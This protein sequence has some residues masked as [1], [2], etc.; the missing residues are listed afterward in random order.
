M[1]QQLINIGGA[2]GDGTGTNW[3]TCWDYTN[4]N[5]TELYAIAND[6]GVQFVGVESDFAVQNATT[7]TLESKKV[8]WI[9]AGITT[10]KRFIVEDGAVLTA[11]NILG[12]PLT[13]TGSGSMFTGTDASFTI[14]DIAIDHPNS[15]AFSFTDNIGGAKLFIASKVRNYTGLKYGTFNN[16]QTV[17]IEGS[18]ALAMDDGISLTGSS[19]IIVSVDKLFMGS[20]SATFKGLDLGSSISQ[21][22]EMSDF[23]VN[24]PSGAY[25]ISGLTSSGNVPSGRLAMVS[26]SEF[27]GGLTPL[28]NIT[29]DDIRWQFSNNTPIP[30]T[31]ADAFLSM[32]ANATATTIA[33]INTPVKVAGIWV[34][35]RQSI[36][37]CTTAGRATYNGERDIV[38]PVDI[39][40]SAA[41]VSGTNKT[42]KIYLAKNGTAIANSEMLSRIDSGDSKNISTMWQ[43]SITTGDYLEVF[44][45]NGSDTTNI[46]V[47][48]ALF[49]VR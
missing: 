30:D 5:F 27:G 45:A 25:G 41:P 46:L 8:Y 35:E 34:I 28:Q 16:M 38:I 12:D 14:Q 6:V 43:L 23:I 24:A 44:V 15:Q 13:Y 21:T 31:F 4:Q 48:D 49:R 17:L 36:F 20:S 10:A 3:R 19:Q 32:R 39:T 22:I 37:T 47:S 7:I 26:N 2:G 40:L 33:A 1:A 18:S 29:T 11:M 42:V 9:T